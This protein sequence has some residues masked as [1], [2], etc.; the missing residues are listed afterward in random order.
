MLKK[1]VITIGFSFL[2]ILTVFK[3]TSA[4]SVENSTNIGISIISPQYDYINRV[5][6]ILTISNGKAT[7]TGSITKT[8]LGGSVYL[9]CTLQ[10]KSNDSWLNIKSWSKSSTTT[11]SVLITEEYEVTYGEYRVATYYSV[12]GVNGTETGTMYSNTV[13]YN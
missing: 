4:F 1:V 5:N 7:I 10:K 13:T 11:T 8:P 6:S 9:R 3:T 2:M 12:N